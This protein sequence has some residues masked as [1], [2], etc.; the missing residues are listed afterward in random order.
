VAS[1]ILQEAQSPEVRMLAAQ[2]LTV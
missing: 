2:I 1:S